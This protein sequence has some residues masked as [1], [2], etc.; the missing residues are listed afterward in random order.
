MASRHATR[1][2]I[3][4]R[5]DHERTARQCPSALEY[6]GTLRRIFDYVYDEAEV[7]DIRGPHLSAWTV[8]WVP[9]R[10]IIAKLCQAMEV[11]SAPAPVVEEGR[12]RREQTIVEH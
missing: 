5:G 7:N 11:T 10:Y 9:S 3:R 12:L 1:F 6:L 4:T 2:P 8:G